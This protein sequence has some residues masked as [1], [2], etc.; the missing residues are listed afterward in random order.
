MAQELRLTREIKK[1]SHGLGLAEEKPAL[2]QF[3]GKSSA[4][5]SADEASV[6]HRAVEVIGDKNDA[7]RWMGTPVRALEYATPVSMLGTR[8]GRQAVVTVLGR[9]EHGV[10]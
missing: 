4:E 2:S 7:L 6:L 5:S 9:L 8:K 3:I 1:R 10:L